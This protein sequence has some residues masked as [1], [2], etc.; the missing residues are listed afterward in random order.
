MIE[1]LNRS[2]GLLLIDLQQGIDDLSH[3]QRNNPEAEQRARQLLSA[4]RELSLPV[5]HVRHDSMNPGSPLR[6]DSPRF[7]YKSGLSP[8]SGEPEFIKRVNGAFTGSDL[9]SWLKTNESKRS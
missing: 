9:E 2:I 5:I 4:W 3:H 7:V 8:R 1:E 6:R